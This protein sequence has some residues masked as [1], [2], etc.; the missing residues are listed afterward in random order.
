MVDAMLTTTSGYCRHKISERSG[1]RGG[2]SRKPTWAER[3]VER[4]SK[5]QVEREREVVGTGTQRWT[6]KICRSKFPPPQ[7]NQFL[8]LKSIFK[9][10]MKLSVQIHY[11]VVC[12]VK[13]KPG[14]GTSLQLW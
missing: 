1:K 8:Q 11:I 4:G 9:V 14:K 3:S 6:G 10:I 12:S 2:A 7:N 13:I 5:N